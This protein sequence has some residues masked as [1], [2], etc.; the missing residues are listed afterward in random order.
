M[1][2]FTYKQKRHT[3]TLRL[4][5]AYIL[6]YTN[7]QSKIFTYWDQYEENQMSA[8]RLLKS[9]SYL[10]G[11]REKRSLIKWSTQINGATNWRESNDQQQ[12]HLFYWVTSNAQPPFNYARLGTKYV[13]R[14]INTYNVLLNFKLSNAP[15]WKVG[16][17]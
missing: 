14:L 2:K 9:C 7:N 1:S 5:S 10:N 11:P 13:L 8:K 3:L 4:Y 6:L 12:Y 15:L 17:I 16:D